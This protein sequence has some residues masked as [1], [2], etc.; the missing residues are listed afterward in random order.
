[1]EAPRNH[2]LVL[3]EALLIAQDLVSTAPTIQQVAAV[4]A[5]AILVVAVVVVDLF[6]AD[7]APPVLLVVQ[8]VLVRVELVVMEPL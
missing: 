4:V 6:P 7:I 5:A 3:E 8:E 2:L 1:M